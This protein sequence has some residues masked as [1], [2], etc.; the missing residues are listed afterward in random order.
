M[1]P[2]DSGP[3]IST[4]LGSVGKIETNIKPYLAPQ[5]KKPKAKSPVSTFLGE[6]AQPPGPASGNNGGKTLLGSA[7]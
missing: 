5:G 7:A 2:T 3:D 1:S 4:L 6:S